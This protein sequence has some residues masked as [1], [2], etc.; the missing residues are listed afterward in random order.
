MRETG[1][2]VR[3]AEETRG[4][5]KLC[6]QN[7]GRQPQNEE[8]SYFSGEI[9]ELPPDQGGVE[10]AGAGR[11]AQRE[12][13][14]DYSKDRH[15]GAAQCNQGVCRSRKRPQHRGFVKNRP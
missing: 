6:D 9:A 3:G 5:E 2:Q 4:R 11:A 8:K 14:G 13:E 12:A 1:G 7:R 10:E 15:A